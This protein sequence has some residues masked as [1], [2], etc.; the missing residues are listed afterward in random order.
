MSG[1]EQHLTLTLTDALAT[2]GHIARL[3]AARLRLGAEG[4]LDEIHAAASECLERCR[5]ASRREA[6]AQEEGERG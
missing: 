5:V 6:E 2:L 3:A 4:R 1:T